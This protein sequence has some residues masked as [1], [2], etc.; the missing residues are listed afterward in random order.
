MPCRLTV[1]SSGFESEV[2][3]SNP[4]GASQKSYCGLA[5]RQRA[6]LIIWMSSVRVRYPRRRSFG[7]WV[8]QNSK[9]KTQNLSRNSVVECRS[10]TAEVKGSNPFEIT[11]DCSL[12]AECQIVVLKGVG[13][14]PIYHPKS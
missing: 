8:A 6:S 4:I 3:G 12:M 1:K 9:P 2:I 10:D 5:Q 13:S 11:G 14:S 7:F